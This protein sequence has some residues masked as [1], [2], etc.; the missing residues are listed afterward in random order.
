MTS[1]GKLVICSC[2]NGRVAYQDLFFCKI[3]QGSDKCNFTLHSCWL[4]IFV[5]QVWLAS[6]TTSHLYLRCGVARGRSLLKTRGRPTSKMAAMGYKNLEMIQSFSS[7][8]IGLSWFSKMAARPHGHI[9]NAI[10]PK[11]GENVELAQIHIHTRLEHSRSNR[12]KIR[13]LRNLF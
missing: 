3:L 10:R 7:R 12:N 2:R 11:F 13:Q 8:V 9:W 4:V 1:S 6:K 5:W